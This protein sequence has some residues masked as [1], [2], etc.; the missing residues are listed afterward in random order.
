MSRIKHLITFALGLAVCCC[1]VLLSAAPQ[2]TLFT[3]EPAEG[4][5]Y[6]VPQFSDFREISSQDMLFLKKILKRAE[7]NKVKAV[8][9]EMDTPG[10]RIDVALEYVSM[11]LK[12]KVPTVAYL[13]PQGIS[14]GMIIA[15]AADRIAINPNGMI[16][17]AMPIQ[18]KSD[19]IKPVTD[20]DNKDRKP[21]KDKQDDVYT[22]MVEKVLKEI[23]KLNRGDKDKEKDK[24][25][26]QDTEDNRL[27]DQKFLTVFFK[28]LE[29]LAQKNDRPEKI[30]RAMADPYQRLTLK[31]DGI[32]HQKASPLTLSAAEAKKLKVV[33]FTCS[34]KE[35]L[36]KELKLTN[37]TIETVIKSPTE[38]IISF[39]AHP[40]V[41]G[42]LLIL[43]IIGLYIEIQHPHFGVSG[44][45]G[46]T[47]LTLFF[48]GHVAS[49]AS[50]WG[51]MVICFVGL[52]LL[53]I[54]IFLIPGFG[55]IGILG[56]SC[57]MISFFAAFGMENIESAI[58]VI[59]ISM[60]VASTLII[61]LT[62]YILP[63]S[64]I[65]KKIMLT[66]QN[67]NVSGFSSHVKND[68]EL[69]HKRGVAYSTLRPSGSIMVDGK[70]Y[71]VVADGDF[72][73]Q[74]ET[75]EVI[76]VDGLKITVKKV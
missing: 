35:E 37:C 57:I 54:E 39:L 42:L 74:G 52:L 29:V 73:Q 26:D 34:S 11:L 53:L 36:L 64:T 28:M 10:G 63:K 14:A 68:V 12:S 16:G 55:I 67:T 43:G 76:Q 65:F 17:D 4:T 70:R 18:I 62:I 49:G 3:A 48:L 30:V 38:Q 20:K 58:S 5:V 40:M 19:G 61:L 15:L 7:K 45:L 9:F 33:D 6:F 56:I 21:D 69:L 22:P 46:L 13:N 27:S 23:Q 1:S 72:I 41:S 24:E 47:A 66:A 60:L 25:K 8:I 31:D 71:D 50:D 32:E 44:V 59:S 75:I 51:P 2:K